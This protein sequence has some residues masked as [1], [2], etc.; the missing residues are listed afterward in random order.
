M[1]IEPF[2][3]PHRRLIAFIEL[4]EGPL[5]CSQV[6]ICLDR[7]IPEDEAKT[8]M[9]SFQWVGFDLT[10]LDHWAK[11]VDVTSD[12]WLFLSMDV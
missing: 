5:D 2:A 6:V 10:T 7:I 8:L 4:A 12:R 1:C 3:N 11:G 9:R